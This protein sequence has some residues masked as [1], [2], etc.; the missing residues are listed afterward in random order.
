MNTAVSIPDP[1]LA[2]VEA[3]ARSLGIS[4]DMLFLEA[5]EQYLVRLHKLQVTQKLNEVYE[6]ESS[7]LHPDLM[8]MQLLSLGDPKTS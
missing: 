6:K 3:A 4:R 5:L 1:L 7:E 2:E 8:K